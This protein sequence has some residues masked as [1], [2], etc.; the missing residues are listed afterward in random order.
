MTW[1][2]LLLLTVAT[3]YAVKEENRDFKSEYIIPQMIMLACK[4][5]GM[6]EIVYISKKVSEEIFGMTVA[7]NVALFATYEGEGQDL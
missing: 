1:L 4:S 2:S 3:S 5:N 7:V 6:D